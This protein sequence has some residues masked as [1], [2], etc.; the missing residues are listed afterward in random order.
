M[1]AVQSGQ[2]GKFSSTGAFNQEIVKLREENSQLKS[3]VT[4]WKVKLTAAEVE[5][6]KKV[7]CAHTNDNV[8]KPKDIKVEDVPA[9]E[10]EKKKP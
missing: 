4:A 8:E 10:D 3:E 7:Y 5:N 1:K 9:P 2:V 6:G